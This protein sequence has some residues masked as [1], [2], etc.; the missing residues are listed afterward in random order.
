VTFEFASPQVVFA[1]GALAGVGAHAARFGRRAL[2]VTGGASL[3]RS[4]ALARALESLR[5]AGVAVERMSVAGEPDTRVI[6]GGAAAA[7]AAACDVVVAIGGGSVLDTGKAVAAVAANGG[8]T[9]DYLE[10]VG[11]GRAL[12][13]A[14]LPVVAVP[15]TAGTG[16]EATRNAVVADAASG[17]KASIRHEH[18]LPRVAV[19]DPLLTHG[20]PH[21]TAVA[22]GMDALTQLIEPYVSRR[23]HPFAR[24]LALD[25]IRRA[26]RALPRVLEHD[27][28]EARGELMLAALWSGLALA[29]AGLGAAHAIAG[30]IGGSFAAPHGAICAATIPHATRVNVRVAAAAGDARTLR[31][32]AEVARALG[33]AGADA[34][35]DADAARAG[36]THLARLCAGLRVPALRAFGV[37]ETAV[38]DVVTRARRTSSI[39]ANPVEL[40]DDDLAEIVRGAIGD[41]GAG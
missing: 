27:D 18:L 41:A 38:D 9:L 15:T 37:T 10:V 1:P 31:R 19:L 33:A 24:A 30:P 29:H 2:L 11:R 8:E 23:D 20:V 17:T 32:Y 16:S 28:T 14:A 13:R 34:A 39:R 7:R 5:D 26:A 22:S 35:D 6:D 40:T 36:A 21:A 25:G 12:E 4:G 3:E